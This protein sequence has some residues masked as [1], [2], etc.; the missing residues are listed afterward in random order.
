MQDNKLLKYF[1]QK[2]KNE[3]I[4]EYKKLYRKYF[5]IFSRIISFTIFLKVNGIHNTNQIE[6]FFSKYRKISKKEAEI[7]KN[8]FH[9][10]E[11]NKLFKFSK[12]E[13]IT[14]FNFK[15]IVKYRPILFLDNLLNNI[16]INKNF[17]VNQTVDYEYGFQETS[18]CEDNKMYYIKFYNMLML[19]FDNIMY[20]ELIS[21]LSPYKDDF[22][23]RIYKTFKGYHVFIV[24]EKIEYN[25]D[26]NLDISKKLESDLMYT[27]FSLYNG[28]VIRLTPKKGY[29]ET[30]THKF[31]SEYGEKSINDD[32]KQLIEKFEN[33]N[34]NKNVY[35]ESQTNFYNKLNSL[36]Y[37]DIELNLEYVEYIVKNYDLK[38]ETIK[39]VS[40]MFVNYTKRPQRILHTN[41]DYYIGVDMY[42]NVH[43]MCYENILMMDIDDS[44]IDNIENKI[45]SYN[46]SYV[47]YKTQNGYHVF[48]LNRRF[49]HNKKET[50]EYMVNFK[51]DYK[52]I[53]C[54]F[55]RGFSVRLNKKYK[56]E[57]TYKLVGYY[58][59]DKI[60]SNILTAV[61]EH[62]F[63][64]K[65]FW[66][67]CKY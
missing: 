15:K 67:S 38:F 65:K 44:S 6:I 17:A 8:N 12:Y 63:F 34:N 5:P 41:S 2:R 29:N 43:Y 55:L 53:I 1:E 50:I 9:P 62:I 58:N 19:D 20:D 25:S 54:S 52:Y 21:K 28:Y 10:K 56:D 40:T 4:K 13:N 33:C 26:K 7:I 46:D 36:N 47:I 51:T 16:P 61:N 35:N 27:S 18:C 49:I 31:I 57:E 60:D 32:L 22:L 37:N 24:S 3:Y 66:I 23:F 42:T 64:S 59:E 30:Q 39:Y 14:H 45:K 11:L 48:V